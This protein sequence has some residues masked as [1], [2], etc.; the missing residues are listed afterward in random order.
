MYVTLRSWK[1]SIINLVGQNGQSYLPF[2]KETVI[3]DFVY[4]LS[5]ANIG[6]SAPNFCKIFTSN[7]IWMSLIMGPIR[8]EQLEL[9]AIELGK[10]WCIR[11]CLLSSI[12]LH[13]PIGTKL[14]LNQ[15][16]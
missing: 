5:S 15:K 14:G 12:Y 6:Q 9:F 11:L 3:F 13:K 10:N 2:I 4:T 8:P 1:N 7:R 16:S